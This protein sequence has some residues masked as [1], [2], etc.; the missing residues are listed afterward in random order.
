M[1]PCHMHD[2]CH[3]SCCFICTCPC[4][5]RRVFE[6][7][8]YELMACGS[9]HSMFIQ[10][11]FG[12]RLSMTAETVIVSAKRKPLFLCFHLIL[13]FGFQSKRTAVRLL[14]P[15]GLSDL[16]PCIKLGAVLGKGQLAGCKSLDCLSSVALAP[17][18][19][20]MVAK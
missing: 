12:S 5:F 1:F 2:V 14:V 17:S 8:R 13:Y 16:K 6:W 11:D 4:S 18:W 9:S 3:V 20:R 10:T 7:F 19:F 15:K